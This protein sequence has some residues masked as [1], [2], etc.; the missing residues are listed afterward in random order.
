[1]I[2]WLRCDIQDAS[3]IDIFNKTDWTEFLWEASGQYGDLD[4]LNQIHSDIQD[5]HHGGYLKILQMEYPPEPY[6]W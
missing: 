1:M 4:L 3:L 2:K 5:G 6:V